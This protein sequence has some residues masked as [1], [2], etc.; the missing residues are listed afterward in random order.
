MSDR[1]V[2][3]HALRLPD[4][5]PLTTIDARERGSAAARWDSF[6]TI[7][8]ATCLRNPSVADF[9][10]TRMSSSVPNFVA[11]RRRDSVSISM[12]EGLGS[13]SVSTMDKMDAPRSSIWTIDAEPPPQ[14][15]LY[16]M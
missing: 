3:L 12:L 11:K 16:P 6:R 8:L 10:A 15:R 14:R 4:G 7:L 9:G 13:P 1:C 5:Y 2:A